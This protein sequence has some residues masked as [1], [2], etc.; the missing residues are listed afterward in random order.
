[1]DSQETRLFEE[2]PALIRC[3]PALNNLRMAG[4]LSDMTIE[5]Q[6]STELRMHKI[7]FVSKIPSLRDAVCGT[8]NDKNTVLKWPNVSPD[9]ARALTDYVYTGQLEISEDS[10]YGL[11]VL[12]KQLVLP[13]VEEWVAAFMASSRLLGHIIN[14]IACPALRADKECPFNRNRRESLSSICLLGAPVTSGKLVMCRYDAESNTLEQLA[15]ITD[16][17]NATFLAAEGKL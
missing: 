6:D 14:W 4:E 10:A 5:L 2:E 12:S 3:L 11:M 15:D 1:M 9:V 16:R 7:I 17:R 8:P 13:K